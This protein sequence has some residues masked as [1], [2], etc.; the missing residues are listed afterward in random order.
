M[1]GMREDGGGCHTAAVQCVR[2]GSVLWEGMP[3]GGLAR[4]L[5]H[6]RTHAGQKKQL[7]VYQSGKGEYTAMA[8]ILI[9]T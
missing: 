4:P 9:H 6:L 7:S 1:R 3:E 5:A 2:K 8:G